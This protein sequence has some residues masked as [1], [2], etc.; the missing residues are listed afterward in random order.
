MTS[1][2]I[3]EFIVGKVLNHVA[4]GVTGKVYNKYRYLEEK[5]NA[6]NKWGRKLE[7]IITGQKAKI[8]ALK[9]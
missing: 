3:Q 4:Q 1:I 7:A 8:I 6:M 2:G 9:K 5:K